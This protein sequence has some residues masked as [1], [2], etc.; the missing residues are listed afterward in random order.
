MFQAYSYL[1]MAYLI[2]LNMVYGVATISRMLKNIGLF[3]KRALQKRP[4]FCKETCIFKHLTHR[5]HPISDTFE[6][7]I[8]DTYVSLEC[9][10]LFL[11]MVAAY[12]KALVSSVHLFAYIYIYMYVY[13]T[14]VCI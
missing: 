6:Y 8:S 14:C 11:H 4:V 10:F 7:G 2:H 13:F 12:K 1:N 3:C 9:T 5:S